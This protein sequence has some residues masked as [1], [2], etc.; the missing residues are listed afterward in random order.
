MKNELT[1]DSIVLLGA[2]AE[3]YVVQDE[4]Q[5]FHWRNLQ[6]ALHPVVI[7]YKENDTLNHVSYCVMS[8]VME[9]DVVMVYQV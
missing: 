6:A 9:H 2:F 3:N 7:Y 5:S 4:V 1:N 8:D